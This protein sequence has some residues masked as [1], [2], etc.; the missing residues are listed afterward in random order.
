MKHTLAFHAEGKNQ[1]S[2]E[3]LYKTTSY[4][5]VSQLGR[6]SEKSLRKGLSESLDLQEWIQATNIRLKMIQTKTMLGHL[7]SVAEGDRTVTR[8]VSDSQVETLLKIRLKPTNFLFFVAVLLCNQG[9]KR[10]RS[11]RLQWPRLRLP[12]Q[13]W[14]LTQFFSVSFL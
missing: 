9:D 1:T 6:P 14:T 8:R 12:A 13:V 4:K 5:N 11:M 10:W 2:N 7:M 3:R